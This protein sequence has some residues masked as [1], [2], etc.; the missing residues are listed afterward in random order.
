MG[1]VDF[2]LFSNYGILRGFFLF[3]FFRDRSQTLV[4]GADAKTGAL[5]L[6]DPCK[7]ALKKIATDFPLKIEFTCF[8]M[9]L[10][11]RRYRDRPIKQRSNRATMCM[12]SLYQ[13]TTYP[14]AC[15]PVWKQRF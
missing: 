14:L 10:T 4:R 6:F 8:S 7:G 13:I 11:K 12:T 5:K 15:V 2:I 3:C 1:Y 9:G